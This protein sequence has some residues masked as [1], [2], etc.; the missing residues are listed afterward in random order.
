MMLSSRTVPSVKDTH[1]RHTVLTKVT[2]PPSYET[3]KHL[4]DEVKANAASVPTT[5]GGGLYGHLGMLLSALKYN[6]LPN[7]TP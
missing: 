4:H 6:V 1:F 7:A 5:L 2:G 3:I